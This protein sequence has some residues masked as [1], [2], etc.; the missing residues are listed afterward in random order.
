MKE[1]LFNNEPESSHPDYCKDTLRAVYGSLIERGENYPL[2]SKT[3]AEQKILEFGAVLVLR[4]AVESAKNS[5]ML[6]VRQGTPK[7]L[8]NLP[9]LLSPSDTLTQQHCLLVLHNEIGSVAAQF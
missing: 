1:S 7:K 5:P 6:K 4:L 9:I 3:S 8:S 2:C